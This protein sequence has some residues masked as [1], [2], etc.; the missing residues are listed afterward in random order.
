LYFILFY[1]VIVIWYYL[2]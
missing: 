2:F 1:V